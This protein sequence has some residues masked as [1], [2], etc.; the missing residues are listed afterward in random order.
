MPAWHVRFTI[1]LLKA[2]SDQVWI[3]CPC[4]FLFPKTD[5]LNLCIL[6]TKDTCA[7]LDLETLKKL[8]ELKT[9]LIILFDQI[10]ISR[11]TL[12]IMHARLF[13][14]GLSLKTNEQQLSADIGHQTKE[15]NEK[16]SWNQFDK[17]IS[18]LSLYM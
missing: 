7:F 10:K 3:R 4:T 18:F 15:R 2:L 13:F 9:F 14:Y 5:Y 16:D 8:S 17:L 6:Y 12:W 1:V 11:I